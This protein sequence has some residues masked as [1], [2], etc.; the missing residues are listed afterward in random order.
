M[1]GVLLGGLAAALFLLL[2][3]VLPVTAAPRLTGLGADRRIDMA[4]AGTLVL[5][6]VTIVYVSAVS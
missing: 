6:V 5:I 1:F 4:L 2:M 3:A